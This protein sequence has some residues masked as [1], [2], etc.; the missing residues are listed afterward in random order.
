[1]WEINLYNMPMSRVGDYIETYTGIKFYPLDPRPEEI[2]IE[3]IAHSL[4]LQ[5][6]FN[7]HCD[8]F[9]SVAEHSVRCTEEYIRR[10]DVSNANPYAFMRM[11]L[12]DSAESFLSDVSAPIKPYLKG[13]QDIENKLLNIIYKKFGVNEIPKQDTLFEPG[14]NP[15]KLLKKVDLILLSTEAASLGMNVSEWGLPYPPLKEQIIPWNSRSAKEKFM[16][17]FKKFQEEINA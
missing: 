13:Y 11:L 7:G 14:I 3:D 2:C 10:C 9:Y 16:N 15:D 8:F 17:D 6:R 12:H 1:M 5:C 4:S